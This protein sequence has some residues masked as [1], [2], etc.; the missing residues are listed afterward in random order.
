MPSLTFICLTE[1]EDITVFC[2]VTSLDHK[3]WDI[4]SDKQELHHLCNRFPKFD[5]FRSYVSG[6]ETFLISHAKHHIMP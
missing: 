1:T 5:T 2:H 3:S 4:R 6:D